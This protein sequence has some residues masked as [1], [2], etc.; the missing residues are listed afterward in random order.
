MFWRC[1]GNVLEMSQKCPENVLEMY[2][3]CSGNVLEMFQDIL[4]HMQ[5]IFRTYANHFWN[6]SQNISR[7]FPGH[8]QNIPKIDSV[9]FWSIYYSYVIHSNILIFLMLLTHPVFAIYENSFNITTLPEIFIQ[10]SNKNWLS[11]LR[12]K[13]QCKI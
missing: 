13:Q 9:M 7:T 3:K 12:Q 8:F 10:R 4:E 2:W 11:L 6:I 1:P 5:N